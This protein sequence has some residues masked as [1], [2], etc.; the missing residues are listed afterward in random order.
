MKTNPMS[1]CFLSGAQTLAR[2]LTHRFMRRSGRLAA[3]AALTL[4]VPDP[5]QAA[6]TELWAHRFSNIMTNSVDRA[7]K[8]VRDSAG[9]IIVVGTSDYNASGPDI[10]T[11]KYSGLDGAILWQQRQPYSTN[12]AYVYSHSQTSLPVAVALDA[13]GN[14]VVSGS[15]EYSENEGESEYYMAKYAGATGAVLWKKRY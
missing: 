13:S 1:S 9:D 6:V 12:P 4:L 10:L 8:V 11:I 7:S 5:L 2:R 15:I 3:L 14:V